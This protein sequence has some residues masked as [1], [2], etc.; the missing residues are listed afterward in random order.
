M[1]AATSSELR[2][3]G[4]RLLAALRVCPDDHDLHLVYSDWL[5]EVGDP[6]RA[7]FVRLML[8]LVRAEVGEPGRRAPE[9][10]TPGYPPT[11]AHSGGSW[12]AYNRAFALLLTHWRRWLP[13]G[14]AGGRALPMTSW[15][16]GVLVAGAWPLARW[17]QDGPAVVRSNPVRHVGIR[18]RRPLHCAWLAWLGDPLRRP[19]L[20]PTAAQPRK[21]HELPAAVFWH[22]AGGTFCRLEDAWAFCIYGS[23]QAANSALSRAC[24]NFALGAPAP[25]P[26]FTALNLQPAGA[27]APLVFKAVTPVTP[28]TLRPGDTLQL[29]YQVEVGDAGRPLGLDALG[30]RRLLNPTGGPTVADEAAWQEALA[31][32]GLAAGASS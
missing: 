4:R 27:D 5:V 19:T 28:V 25:P 32:S 17:L 15:R 3:T 23:E 16:R 12:P 20:V 31:Y 21:R 6:A 8:D 29:K 26:R 1:G 9:T 2:Q 18:D 30:L 7:E 22:L 11:T 10:I 14:H 24:L 13:A